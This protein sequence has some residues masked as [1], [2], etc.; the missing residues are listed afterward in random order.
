MFK[1]KEDADIDKVLD[2]FSSH[3]ETKSHSMHI[4]IQQCKK[5]GLNIEDIE[6]NNELQDLILT[7]HHTFMH[8]FYTTNVTKIIENQMGI[9]F[10]EGIVER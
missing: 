4:S 1:G 3:K 2:L 9:G 8:A 6:A 5:V 10:I 7:V